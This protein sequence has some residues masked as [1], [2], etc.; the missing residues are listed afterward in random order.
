MCCP[1]ELHLLWQSAVHQGDEGCASCRH[2]SWALFHG[3]TSKQVGA[4][5][6]SCAASLCLFSLLFLGDDGIRFIKYCSVQC[7]YSKHWVLQVLKWLVSM[8]WMQFFPL[9]CSFSLE[10]LTLWPAATRP[11]AANVNWET[12]HVSNGMY[13][14]YLP[15]RRLVFIL[16]Q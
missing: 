11:R 15:S 14:L 10:L 2:R 12:S 7:L 5:W 13:T 8:Y 6:I 9:E 4:S 1:G 16:A 3:Y